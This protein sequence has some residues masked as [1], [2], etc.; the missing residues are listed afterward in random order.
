MNKTDFYRLIRMLPKSELHIH[1]EAVLSSKTI[2][3]VYKRSHGKAIT[4]TEYA[5]LFDYDD[6]AGFLNSFIKIQSFFTDMSDLE[7]LFQDFSDYLEKNNIVYCETFFSPTSH[8]KKGWNF[9]EMMTLVSRSIKRIKEKT[10]R[11]VKLIVDVSRTFGVENAMK[12]LDLVLEAKNPD[13][14]GIGLG[15]NE[16]TGPAKDFESVFKKARENGL[17]VVA[18]AGEICPSSSI[19]DSI[20]LLGAERIGH[21]IS[22]AFDEEFMAQLKKDKTPIEVCPTSNV[23][24]KKYVTEMKNHPVRKLFDS[25]VNVCIN[26]DDPTFFKVSI[27]DE[28]WNLYKHLNFSLDEIKQLIKNGFNSLFISDEKKKSYCSEVEKVGK[29]FFTKNPTAAE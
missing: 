21:G 22:A 17:H 11:T 1:Q 27:I 14:I 3:K 16:V 4:N 18:H 23:C 19:K 20:N 10:G 13:I 12:N 5:S 9:Q 8:L 2:K 25:G 6:L 24:T 26:T 29:E 15:G 28:Y 7:F